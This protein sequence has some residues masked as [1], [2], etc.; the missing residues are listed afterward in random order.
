MTDEERTKK[1]S[2]LYKKELVD[3]KESMK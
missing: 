2:K 1:A 3:I